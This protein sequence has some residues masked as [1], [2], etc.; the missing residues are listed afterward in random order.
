MCLIIVWVNG[1]SSL[2]KK[3]DNR[4]LFRFLF[5]FIYIEFGVG[6]LCDLCFEMILFEMNC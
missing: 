2:V 4:I 1:N 5:C 3:S 6:F